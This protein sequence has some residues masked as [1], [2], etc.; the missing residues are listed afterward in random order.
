MD[1]SET[2]DQNHSR[3]PESRNPRIRVRIGI[4]LVFVSCG[5]WFSLFVVPFLPLTLSQKTL[6]AGGIFVGVQ[7]TWWS[8]A[9]LAGPSFVR[10]LRLAFSSLLKSDA[11][12]TDA[13]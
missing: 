9:A 4:V 7:V 2:D 1:S 5:M 12:V 6:L 10:K 3:T 13:D 11:D 8:G